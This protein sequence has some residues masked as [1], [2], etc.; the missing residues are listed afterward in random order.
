MNNDITHRTVLTA[1]GTSY[2]ERFQKLVEMLPHRIYRDGGEE[3]VQFP[4]GLILE[5]ETVAG[6]E[7]VKRVVEQF[8]GSSEGVTY[9]GLLHNPAINIPVRIIQQLSETGTQAVVEALAPVVNLSND[10]ARYRRSLAE[11]MG[12]VDERR[13][14][15]FQ[16]TD[17]ED[18]PVT[19]EFTIPQKWTVKDVVRASIG[20]EFNNALG[21]RLFHSVFMQ[22]GREHVKVL[23]KES[24]IE[25]LL[26]NPNKGK[27]V[28]ILVARL[29]E[30]GHSKDPR[31]SIS[32]RI[33][34]KLLPHHRK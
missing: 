11:V 19:Y 18:R 34:Q 16:Y 2:L 22:P 8:T 23:I 17:K 9:N 27:L 28:E 5:R 30:A 31:A 14:Q 15:R 32:A 12:I 29:G 3:K 13:I 1:V 24:D 26:E 7:Q 10:A 20:R 21:E 33:T 25:R 4:L 6:T